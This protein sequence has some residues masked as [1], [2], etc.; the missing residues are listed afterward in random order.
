MPIQTEWIRG[1]HVQNHDVEFFFPTEISRPGSGS[2][3][4]IVT[5]RGG[6][7]KIQV[8]QFMINMLVD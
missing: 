3:L 1:I 2:R 6:D 7:E 4:D 8:W 5:L